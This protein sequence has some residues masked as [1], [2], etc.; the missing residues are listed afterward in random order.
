[1]FSSG[2]KINR[3]IRIFMTEIELDKFKALTNYL[4]TKIA[5]YH[6]C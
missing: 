6:P 3:D 5:K 1:M 4:G 2:I